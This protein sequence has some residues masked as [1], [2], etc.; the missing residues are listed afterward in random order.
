MEASGVQMKS[1]EKQARRQF[2]PEFKGQEVKPQGLPPWRQTREPLVL[3]E[4]PLVLYPIISNGET[5]IFPRIVI[6]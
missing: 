4:T 6:S 1:N 5:P 3:S 2:T